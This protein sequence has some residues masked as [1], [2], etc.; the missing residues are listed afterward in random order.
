M[1]ISDLQ[2]EADK[3][4]EMFLRANKDTPGGLRYE[5]ARESQQHTIEPKVLARQLHMHT[6]DPYEGKR[7]FG[8]K[9]TK[10][11]A[12]HVGNSKDFTTGTVNG[13]TI[14]FNSDGVIKNANSMTPQYKAWIK[15]HG[16]DYRIQPFSEFKKKLEKFCKDYVAAVKLGVVTRTDMEV[17]S[18]SS[19]K[20]VF[21]V[22][23]VTDREDVYGKLQS[24]TGDIANKVAEEDDY[25][26]MFANSKSQVSGLIN[27]GHTIAVAE[28][29]AGIFDAAVKGGKTIVRS[30]KLDAFDEKLDKALAD[31]KLQIDLEHVRKVDWQSKTLKDERVVKTDAE[32]YFFNQARAGA[33]E[34][35]GIKGGVSETSIG[36][37]IENLLKE[38]KKILKEEYNNKAL[39][40]R[41]G[42]QTMLQAAQA[43]ILYTAIDKI[44]KKTLKVSTKLAKPIKGKKQ[45]KVKAPSI[46]F[47]R[48]HKKMRPNTVGLGNA[49]PGMKKIPNPPRMNSESGTSLAPLIALLNSKLPETV[50]RNMGPPGL[51]NQTGR[52]ASSVRV[53]DVSRTA[54]GFPSVGYDYRRNPY[55]VFEM[56]SGQ[57]PWASP[58]RDPRKVIDQSIREIAA[59]FAIGRFY[60]RR[61]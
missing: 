11:Y 33:P 9:D 61:I 34:K 12:S 26:T 31:L 38:Y 46:T 29:K 2:L 60:T 58:D 37:K 53:T 4:Q 21:I 20:F 30:D 52:F 50:A 19:E 14:D 3:L 10:E 47:K 56:G 57:A 24:F 18:P 22:S 25:R 7:Y 6:E 41:K 23:A 17:I 28:E 15:K 39:A 49:K 45:N 16:E 13:K 5:L 44:N 8:K 32:S 40:D 36:K 42:S 43:M 55:Q 54:Q 51:E 48:G 1:A 35:A 27:V 59:Q